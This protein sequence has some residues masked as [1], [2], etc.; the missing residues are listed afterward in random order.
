MLLTEKDSQ[1]ALME[2]AGA[3][4]QHQIERLN[5]LHSDRY[6]INRRLKIEVLFTF[7]NMFCIP[8][9]ECHHFQ[10]EKSVALLLHC[11]LLEKDLFEFLSTTQ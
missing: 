10:S 5:R 9:H 4:T 3:K 8:L 1:I 2:M 11:D 6:K 7:L